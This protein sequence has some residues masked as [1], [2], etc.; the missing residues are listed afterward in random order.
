[1]TAKKIHIVGVPEHFNL[2]WRL[3]ASSD[4]PAK[5]GVDVVWQEVREGTGAML[6][7]LRDG[8]ADMAMLLTE[9]A[10]A[11]IGNGGGLEIVGEYVS[12]PLN[13]GIHTAAGGAL[14]EESTL[15]GQRFAI[16]RYG[17]GSH[18]MGALYADQY[19][20]AGAPEYVVVDNL[21]GAREALASGQAEIFLWEQF[22]TQPY[23]D[24]G[25]FQRVGVFPT[26]WPC[27]VACRGQQSEHD[28][29]LL[30]GLLKLALDAAHLLRQR[31]A[32]DTMIADAYDLDPAQVREWLSLTRW[33]VDG[34]FDPQWV[35]IA[36]DA[37]VN[38]GVLETMVPA[39]LALANN[40]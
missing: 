2:P 40:C 12:S 14:T 29:T 4:L 33:S 10:V 26:P 20:W 30:Q 3:L 24:N 23:V 25:E 31:A 6:E 35:A 36:S 34:A 22:T 27:F 11:G 32:L 1:M 28:A 5:L 17:S 8:T 19:D 38:V 37:L 39:T 21:D 7:M 18:L 13:W 9:G 15:K 16:S